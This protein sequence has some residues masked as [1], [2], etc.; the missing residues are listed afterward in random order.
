MKFSS[1]SNS[2]RSKKRGAKQSYQQKP[3]GE[4]IIKTGPKRQKPTMTSTSIYYIKLTIDQHE[5]HI[6]DIAQHRINRHINGYENWNM[7]LCYITS[8]T[9]QQFEKNNLEQKHG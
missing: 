2:D 1:I 5:L 9:F 8:Y 6:G 7:F 4:K 3:K